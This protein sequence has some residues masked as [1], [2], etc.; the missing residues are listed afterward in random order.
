M[1]LIMRHARDP[2][3]HVLQDIAQRINL[4]NS[5]RCFFGGGGGGGGGAVPISGTVC[6]GLSLALKF[7]IAV[8]STMLPHSVV[9]D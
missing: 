5:Y 3:Q 6:T 2:L 4:C 8:P 7:F 1:C 9:N